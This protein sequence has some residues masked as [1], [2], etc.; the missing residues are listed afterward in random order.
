MREVPEEEV[1][2]R[3]EAAG[4]EEGH[5]KWDRSG[6]GAVGES[7][8]GGERSGVLPDG[9][10][11]E[12]IALHDVEQTWDKGRHQSPMGLIVLAG[13]L[14]VLV[15]VVAMWRIPKGDALVAEKESQLAA[16]LDE[17]EQ[18]MEDAGV[19]MEHIEVVLKQ[20]LEA[21]TLEEKLQHVRHRD[22]VKPL[23]ENY[24]RTH[25]MTPRSYQCVTSF[26][27]VG[28][29]NKPYV[30]MQVRGEDETLINLLLEQVGDR[31]LRVDWETDVVYQ[32]MPLEEFLEKRPAEGVDFR[33]F[34]K[35]DLFYA[36][37]FGEEEYQSL[38]LTER[39]SD[40]YLFGYLKR[41]TDTYREV[42]TLVGG[43]PGRTE[44][45]LLKLRILPGSESRRSVL[46]EEVVAPRW[47]LMDGREDGE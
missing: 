11:Q 7:G 38:M 22:R 46:V 43:L 34:V 15:L 3:L 33:V 47:A 9:E 44:P 41:G 14:G 36:Y 35:P 23:M 5:G 39:D 24:Y 1:V 18:S 2:V 21:E 19:L 28:V 32:P 37:E 27:P 26:Y 16:K 31:D 17:E 25:P 30:Y 45:M 20:Y 13:I 10:A 42:M 29:E 6:V 8:E 40:S 12:E 4:Q